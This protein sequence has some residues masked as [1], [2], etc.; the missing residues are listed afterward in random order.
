MFSVPFFFFVICGIE[1]RTS[2]KTGRQQQQQLKASGWPDFLSRGKVFEAKKGGKKSLGNSHVLGFTFRVLTIEQQ[3]ETVGE[4][5]LKKREAEEEEE[6]VLID[7]RRREE[8]SETR[9]GS[10]ERVYR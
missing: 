6:E 2:P 7:G 9:R 3:Q 1:K 4:K 8:E 10:F 5:T